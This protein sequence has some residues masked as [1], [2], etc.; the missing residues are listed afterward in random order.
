[1]IIGFSVVTNCPNIPALSNDQ[2]M[3]FCLEFFRS[4]NQKV[5]LT[6]LIIIPSAPTCGICASHLYK[7]RPYEEENLLLL[8]ETVLPGESMKI[9]LNSKI[10]DATWSFWKLFFLFFIR[11]TG[12]QRKELLYMLEK[13]TLNTSVFK[14]TDK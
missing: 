11:R 8:W 13:I 10:T 7:P 14:F 4:G 6:H 1:M 2:Y 12:M 9:S 3:A 5:R